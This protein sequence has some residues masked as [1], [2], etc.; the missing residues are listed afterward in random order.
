MKS[1]YLLPVLILAAMTG[2]HSSPSDRWA[3]ARETLTTA[4]DAALILHDAG[5]IDDETIVFRVQPAAAAARS[6]LDR[7]YP[8]LPA[9]PGVEDYLDIAEAAV[10]RLVAIR[11]EYVEASP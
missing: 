3:I 5:A 11:T 8:L 2:C 1:K 10:R 7:A 6:A 4:Q 9:E